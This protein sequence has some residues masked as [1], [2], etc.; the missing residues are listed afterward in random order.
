MDAMM[1]ELVKGGAYSVEKPFLVICVRKAWKEGSK[2][3]RVNV[4]LPS[5]LICDF[6][7][8]LGSHSPRLKRVMALDQS[9]I[10]QRLQRLTA[11]LRTRTATGGAVSG[12]PDDAGT[13]VALAAYLTSQPG[14]TAQAEAQSA[15]PACGDASVEQ[16][17][18]Q[19][20]DHSRFG[21]L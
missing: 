14:A 20:S 3:A 7:L 10:S 9:N 16:A 1:G 12:P 2:E 6:I 13:V 15:E 5:S 21:N 18:Q 8:L 19:A 17:A 4:N 11:T